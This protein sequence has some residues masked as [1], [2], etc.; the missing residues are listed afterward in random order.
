MNTKVTVSTVTRQVTVNIESVIEK[1]GIYQPTQRPT[2]RLVTMRS[3][4]GEKS[5]FY[6]N[7]ESELTEPL[8][9]SAWTGGA[10][11]IVMNET[12][13]LSFVRK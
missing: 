3:A 12:L 8:D 4:I 13:E 1:E 11:F 7:S 5:T 9:R 10:R 2:T 6:C